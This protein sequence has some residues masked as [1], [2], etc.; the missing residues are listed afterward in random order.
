MESQ[1][2][3]NAVETFI[4]NSCGLKSFSFAFK[5]IA[6]YQKGYKSRAS[7]RLKQ[8]FLTGVSRGPQKILGSA[9]K[10]INLRVHVTS[11]TIHRTMRQQ[12]I[13]DFFALRTRM[14]APN[15]FVDK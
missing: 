10:N 13:F 12:N 15:I 9:G 7:K 11:L 3:N 5:M 6:F 4:F 1:N 8:G 14:R 2:V